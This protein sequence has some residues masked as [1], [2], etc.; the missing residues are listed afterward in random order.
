[1]FV[2]PKTKLSE[3]TMQF[4]E[5]LKLCFHC[6]VTDRKK[7]T[8]LWRD[9]VTLWFYSFYPL[10]SK[11]IPPDINSVSE[12]ISVHMEINSQPIW[13][14]SQ[15]KCLDNITKSCVLSFSGVCVVML[16]WLLL[17]VPLEYNR[18]LD[19]GAEQYTWDSVSSTHTHTHTHTR[20]VHLS[21]EPCES[22]R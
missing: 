1:M 5:I 8:K 7:T 2:S 9:S 18:F 16:R 15:I 21:A 13:R 4:G 11:Q 3:N 20:M 19:S 17:N 14:C 10:F 12:N 22:W 6:R